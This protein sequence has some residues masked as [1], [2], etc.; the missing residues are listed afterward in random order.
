VEERPARTPWEFDA[1][2]LDKRRQVLGGLYAPTRAR[3]AAR[4]AIF[5]AVVEVLLVAARI[6]VDELDQPPETI[7]NEAPWAEPDARQR[8][9]N[10]I[11]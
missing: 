9:P 8:K 1:M 6:A 5:V 2:G 4:L 11:Q 7:S 3:I 10:P